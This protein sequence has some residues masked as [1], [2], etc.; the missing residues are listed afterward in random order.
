ML[1]TGLSCQIKPKWVGHVVTK[2]QKREGSY[3]VR[4]PENGD[5]SVQASELRKYFTR[6]HNV[7]V[8]FEAENEFGD[9]ESAPTCSVLPMPR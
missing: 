3:I 7:G 5:R 9:V 2:E 1:E 6:A 4:S 8:I